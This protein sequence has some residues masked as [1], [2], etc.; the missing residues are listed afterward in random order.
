MSICKQIAFSSDGFLLKGTLHLPA[1]EA[2]PPVIIGS[3]GLF[4]SGTSPKQ[5]ALA[6]RCLPYGIAFLRF[7]HRGCGESEGAFNDVT[8][9]EARCS[10]LINAVNMIRSRN[11]TGERIGLFGS[12]MGGAVCLATAG[13]LNADSLVTVAAPV[14]IASAIEAVEAIERSAALNPPDPVFYKKELRFDIADK[15]SSLRNILIFHG[16]ADNVIPISNAEEIYQKA[17]DPKKLIIQKQGDHRISDR[18][19]QEE[20]MRE[21][22]SWFK[23]TLL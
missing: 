1:S 23:T 3:H 8:S 17:G 22:V 13:M 18:S 19:H 9:L 14:R 16:D 15:L 7:D 2:H 12:S 10:D 20:F 11:D 5:I 6:E 21:T 4:S